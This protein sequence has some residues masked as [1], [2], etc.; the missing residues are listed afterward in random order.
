MSKINEYF[1]AFGGNLGPVEENFLKAAKMIEE[2]IGKISIK[3]SIYISKA[4]TLEDSSINKQNDYLNCVISLSSEKKEQ[5]VLKA[6]NQIENTLGRVRKKRWDSRTI[7][8]DIVALGS[9]V[10]ETANLTIPHKEMHKR[11]F[12]LKPLNEID[13]NWVHPILNKT[14]GELLEALG[15][16]SDFETPCENLKLFPDCEF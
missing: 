11:T 2:E 7:D 15:S 13:S 5:E 8:L 14:T 9:Q 1:I 6:L 3:S 12:V 16:N 4:L 10:V